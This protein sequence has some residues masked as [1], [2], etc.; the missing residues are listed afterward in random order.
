MFLHMSFDKFDQSFSLLSNRVIKNYRFLINVRLV[1]GDLLLLVLYTIVIYI[2]TKIFALAICVN[3]KLNSWYIKSW[4]LNLITTISTLLI[5]ILCSVTWQNKNISVR[6][7]SIRF[8]NIR[9]TDSIPVGIV[10]LW[11][12]IALQST[13]GWL[14]SLS[15]DCFIRRC[16]AW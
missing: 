14:R 8:R 3:H 2:Y 16:R 4:W 10:I 11:W 13:F 1:L 7:H 9:R 15:W 6:F 12:R 5:I